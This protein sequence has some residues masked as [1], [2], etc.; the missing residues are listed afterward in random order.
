M[1]RTPV[2]ELVPELGET[3]YASEPLPEPEPPE[4]IV[5]QLTLAVE[6]QVQPEPAVTATLPAPPATENDWFAG[7]ME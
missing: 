7:D 4:A 2:L 1:V 3:V 5:I 6:V